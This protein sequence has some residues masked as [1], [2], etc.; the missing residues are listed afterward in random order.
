M[1]TNTRTLILLGAGG[2]LL[3]LCCAGT[4]ILAAAAYFRATPSPSSRSELVFTPSEIPDGRVGEPYSVRI[5]VSDNVTPVFDMW[6][7]GDSLP[8]GLTFTYGENS[9]T[10][11]IAGIP[12]VPG[13]FTFEVGAACFGTNVSGQTGSHSYTL[14][15]K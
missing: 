13:T 7:D 4:V 10:A 8:T 14:V 3:V 15:V 9:D 2:V 11:E 1:K 12:E 5:S 6:M